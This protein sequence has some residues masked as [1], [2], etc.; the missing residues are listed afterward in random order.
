MEFYSGFHKHFFFF[1]TFVEKE[2]LLRRKNISERTDEELLELHRTSGNT[3]YFGELYN[4]YMPLLY[5]LCLK[6]LQQEEKAQDA[7]MQLFEELLPKIGG[8]EIKVF[9][10]WLY[11][12]VKN[13][14]LQMLRR[15]SKEIVVDFKSDLMESD[16]ILHLLSEEESDAERMQALHR[17][18]K[19]LPDGQRISILHFFMEE[20]S[21]ADIVEKTGYPLKTVKSNIQNGKRNLKICIKKHTV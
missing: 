1:Y 14:C 5:G 8:Y 18:L 4:R 13:H 11:S 9:R 19:R 17:C 20:C 7:V 2:L 21:Y 12:V 15:E 3:E 10:T 16:E 6:Y